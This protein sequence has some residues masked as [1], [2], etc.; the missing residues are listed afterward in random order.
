VLVGMDAVAL[1]AVIRVTGSSDQR[2]FA[3]VGRRSGL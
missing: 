1:D 2:L 3:R